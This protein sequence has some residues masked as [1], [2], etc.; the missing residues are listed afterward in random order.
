MYVIGIALCIIVI[1]LFIITNI[2]KKQIHFFIAGHNEHFSLGEIAALWKAAKK[3]SLEEPRSIFWSKDVLIDCISTISTQNKIEHSVSEKFISKLYKMR[4]KLEI[5]SMSKNVITDTH[6]IESGQRIRIVLHGTGAF[7]STLV[8]N[9]REFTISSPT[10]GGIV[11]IP[12]TDWVGEK[13]TVYI[14]RTGDARYIFD[15]DVMSAG[16]YKGEPVL[17]LR[18]SKKLMRTQKRKTLRTKCHIPATMRIMQSP[19]NKAND[20]SINSSSNSS[21]DASITTQTYKCIL[22]DI[23]EAGA[24]IRLKGKCLPDL[25]L[26]LQFDIAEN[27]LVVDGIVRTVEY[28]KFIN[29]SHAHFEF[30]NISEEK[31]NIILDYV[32]E[33]LLKKEMEA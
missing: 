6:Q 19:Y 15:T 28:N 3:C 31:Q 9:I 33:V 30:K 12:S 4:T 10:L 27:N 13:V 20:S 25:N 1:F 2:Y 16:V 11:T 5:E 17:Y 14:W 29:Q 32:Y 7:S 23:S 8:N 22:D 21:I 26:V 24:L 18:H